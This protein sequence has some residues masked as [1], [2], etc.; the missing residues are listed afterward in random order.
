MTFP[1][2]KF[3]KCPI[4]GG[5]GTDDSGSGSHHSTEDHTSYG[6]PLVYYQ[7]RLMCKL[8]RKRLMAYEES[9]VAQDKYNENQRFLERMGARKTME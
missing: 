1:N 8:C 3:G 7:G 4:H 6:Y 2:E 9:K 5:G